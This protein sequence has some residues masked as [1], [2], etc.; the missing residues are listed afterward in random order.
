MQF[1]IYFG[2]FHSDF[3]VVSLE[4]MEV[5]DLYSNDI[6]VQ[7]LIIYVPVQNHRT[8]RE[9]TEFTPGFWENV[10]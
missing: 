2:K 6:H 10:I 5:L 1:E 9:L 3:K 4:D 7:N 8:E